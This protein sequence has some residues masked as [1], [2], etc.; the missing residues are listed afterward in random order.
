M[1]EFALPSEQLNLSDRELFGVRKN[2][3]ETMMKKNNNIGEVQPSSIQDI[4]ANQG[5]GR[6]MKIEVISEGE[7]VASQP[8]QPTAPSKPVAEEAKNLEGHEGGIDEWS[9]SA[10][11][12]D[13]WSVPPPTESFPPM[14]SKEGTIHDEVESEPRRSS[15]ADS[16]SLSPEKEE[17]VLIFIQP[18]SHFAN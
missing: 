8:T 12:A 17:E 10:P 13:E 9:I 18:L 14:S 5:Q 16:W 15:K 6:K 11:P 3:V 1:E 2:E 7:T 4:I